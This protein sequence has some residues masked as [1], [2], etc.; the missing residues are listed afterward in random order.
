MSRFLWFTVYIHATHR[1][2]VEL[3]FQ[4]YIVS[5]TSHIYLNVRGRTSDVK[6]KD[7]WNMTD[8]GERLRKLYSVLTKTLDAQSVGA[9]MFADNALTLDEL[10]SIQSKRKQPG[11]A[12]QL[13]LKIVIAQSSEVYGCFLNALNRSGDEGRDLHRLILENNCKG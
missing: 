9:A 3:S 7:I 13:L 10:E 11:K 8:H 1:K 2:R 5:E 12:A 6:S 4:L